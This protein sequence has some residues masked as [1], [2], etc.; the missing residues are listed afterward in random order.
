MG[1]PPRALAG[2][3]CLHSRGREGGRDK[4]ITFSAEVEAWHYL[5]ESNLDQNLI[6][7]LGSLSCLAHWSYHCICA[8]GQL[9]SLALALVTKH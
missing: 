3:S 7:Q 4:D 5:E 6:Q 9:R 1:R 8:I 2:N